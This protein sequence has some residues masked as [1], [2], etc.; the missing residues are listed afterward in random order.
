M[1]SPKRLCKAEEVSIMD[2]IE[3]FLNRYAYI[4]L[5][6]LIMLLLFLIIALAVAVIDITSAH[7]TSVVM[8]ESGNYYNHLNDVI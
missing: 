6:I 8:V 4:L 1:S 5:P 2:L 7:N 3:I